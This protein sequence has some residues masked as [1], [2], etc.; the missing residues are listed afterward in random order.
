M[1]LL[2]FL[3]SAIP[4]GP[5]SY[6]L[7]KEDKTYYIWNANTGLRYNYRDN[8]CPVQSVGCLANAENIW[9]NIQPLE[10][11]ARMSFDVKNTANWKPFF[12]SR[13]KDPGLSSV[14]V[15]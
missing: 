7:T 10:Q 4:E 14:Q 11:P 9:A 15:S 5:T 6:V 8:Y 12:H 13:F 1:I 2:H 3:G